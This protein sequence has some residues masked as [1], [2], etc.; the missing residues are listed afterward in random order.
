MK[1]PD[2]HGSGVVATYNAAY[3]YTKKCDT[4]NG[5]GV[6]EPLTNEEWLRSLGTT[7][8]MAKAIFVIGTKHCCWSFSEGSILRWLKEKH[9]DNN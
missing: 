1:C 2:C 5:N 6:V 9:N 7:E 8:E 4:C 3:V